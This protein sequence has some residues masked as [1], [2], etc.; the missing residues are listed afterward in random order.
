MKLTRTICYTVAG[1]LALSS[2]P[3]AGTTQPKSSDPRPWMK[4]YTPTTLEWVA[5]MMSYRY[6]DD[7]YRDGIGYHFSPFGDEATGTVI[8][9]LTYDPDVKV[10]DLQRVET[11]I[12]GWEEIQRGRYPW[13]RVTV[14]RLEVPVK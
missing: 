9:R 5:F 4:P 7:D 10:G 3:H 2:F 6:S 12:K 11:I 14:E 1:I 8:C 13:L